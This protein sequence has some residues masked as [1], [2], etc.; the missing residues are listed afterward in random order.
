MGLKKHPVQ[1][2]LG[3]ILP[4]LSRDGISL[5]LPTV[6]CVQDN[7]VQKDISDGKEILIVSSSVLYRPL[8]LSERQDQEGAYRDKVIWSL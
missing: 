2:C 3:N 1:D 4:A 7:L 6:P 5:V 8:V